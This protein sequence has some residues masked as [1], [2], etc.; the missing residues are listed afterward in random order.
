MQLSLAPCQRQE[1][2][3]ELRLD[4][5]GGSTGETNTIF[6]LV[7]KRLRRSAKAQRVFAEI[8]DPKECE[9][10]SFR[11][12]MDF[13][14]AAIFPEVVPLML[15][16]YEGEGL[17]LREQITDAG[18]FSIEIFL[19][20]AVEAA[21]MADDAHLEFDWAWLRRTVDIIAHELPPVRIYAMGIT[22]L[23]EL[24]DCSE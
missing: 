11:S 19:L 10:D 20:A 15:A 1:F 14:V 7:E 9:C 16:F 24:A 4:L 2:K 5:V 8:E 21:I 6:P 3:L 12:Y 23:V 18:R 22:P 13:F 17:P